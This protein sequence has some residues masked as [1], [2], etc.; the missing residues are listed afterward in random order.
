MK[1]NNTHYISNMLKINRYIPDTGRWWK[2][3]TCYK[4]YATYI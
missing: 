4:K 2:N 3:P 1:L